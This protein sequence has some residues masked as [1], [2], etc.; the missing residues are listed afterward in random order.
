MPERSA[1]VRRVDRQGGEPRPAA[2][3]RRRVNEPVPRQA[4]SAPRARS[5]GR[6][7][8]A[9]LAGLTLL[10]LAWQLSAGGDGS[11]AEQLSQGCHDVEA[12]R[13][14]EAE[15]ARR[16]QACWLGCGRSEA[17]HRLAR[18]LRY[19]A[20]ERSAVREHY[21]QRDDA[22]RNER[23]QEHAER[24]AEQQRER[25]AQQARADREQR[26][27]LE[28][29]RLRQ[30]RL[31]RRNA[32]ERQRRVAY[33][34]LLEP[35]ARAARLERCH[36]QK[37]GCDELVLDLIEAAEPAEKRK[38]VALNERL[39]SGGGSAAARTEPR[40]EPATQASAAGL[41]PPNS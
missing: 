33:L 5:R 34:A 32:E 37:A 4:L 41:A 23:Q 10:G 12:C 28:L 11:L 36:A 16:E 21:R 18:S 3:W 15:A 35:A 40:R 30:D 38:L 24:V 7:L 17:E 26:E 9:A 1:L 27:R 2:R 8:G 25:A 19:R 13:A 6:L 14:L 31:D 20:E 22:E 39:L 29:E